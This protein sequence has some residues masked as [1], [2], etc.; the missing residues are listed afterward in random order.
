MVAVAVLL[1]WLALLL[2]GRTLQATFCLG[3]QLTL[4][5]WIPAA[6]WAVRVVNNDRRDRQYREMLRLLRGR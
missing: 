1:P 3:L 4:V 2:R 5:G 6:I